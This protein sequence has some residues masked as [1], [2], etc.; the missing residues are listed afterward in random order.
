MEITSAEA[1][2][3]LY[4]LVNY[5]RRQ[6]HNIDQQVRRASR[7]ICDSFVTLTAT[8]Q[9][10]DMITLG[11]VRWLPFDDV[12]IAPLL[13]PGSSFTSTRAA[14]QSTPPPATAASAP[15]S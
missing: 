15:H 9:P 6:L 8:P 12:T 4:N 2:P 13:T 10:L 11:H 5:T 14:P 7:L 1:L 3:R